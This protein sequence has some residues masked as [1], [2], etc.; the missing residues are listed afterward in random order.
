M[1]ADEMCR[2]AIMDSLGT[3]ISKQQKAKPSAVGGSRWQY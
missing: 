1:A 2:A 3:S